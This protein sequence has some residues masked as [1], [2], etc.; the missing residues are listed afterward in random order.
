ME[1]PT[2]FWRGL[3]SFP[4]TFA[5]E[6]FIDELAHSANID[7]IQFRL[8]NLPQDELGERMR[9]ALETVRETSD[10]ENLSSELRR[11]RYS[12]DMG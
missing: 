7:P 10:W 3:G 11:T 1:I 5:V 4:N 6:A 8:N 2:G 9:V 12:H